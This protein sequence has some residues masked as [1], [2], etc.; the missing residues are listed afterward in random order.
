VQTEVPAI[1]T[2]TLKSEAEVAKLAT[3]VSKIEGGFAVISLTQ[4]IVLGKGWTADV[5]GERRVEGSKIAKGDSCSLYP[6][7]DWEGFGGEMSET[8]PEAKFQEYGDVW[9]AEGADGYFTID[10]KKDFVPDYAEVIVLDPFDGMPLEA[11]TKLVKGVRYVYTLRVYYTG[12]ITDFESV[13]YLAGGKPKA[14][15]YWQD[16]NTTA[17]VLVVL[18]DVKLDFDPTQVKVVLNGKSLATGDTVKAGEEIQI[19]L[20]GKRPAAT[21]PVDPGS[22]SGSGGGGGGGCSTGGFGLLGLAVLPL[23]RKKLCL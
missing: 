18:A 4:D 5:Y 9:F 16:I 22:G 23:I 19:Q 10:V 8:V 21:K 1:D 6:P 20:K 2:S 15:E 13:D 3:T 12:K 7:T 11:G 17:M 14:E